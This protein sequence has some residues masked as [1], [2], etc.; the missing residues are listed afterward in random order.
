MGMELGAQVSVLRMAISGRP[1]PGKPGMDS[2]VE[3]RGE[4][5]DRLLSS[6][7]PIDRSRKVDIRA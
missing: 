7:M 4:L 5:V 3:S 6:A 2:P 1:P